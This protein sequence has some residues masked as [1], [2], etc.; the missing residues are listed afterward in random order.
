MLFL[1]S[2]KN[3]RYQLVIKQINVQ[4]NTQLCIKYST[5]VAMFC[6]LYFE[7]YV[8]VSRKGSSFLYLMTYFF[9]SNLNAWPLENEHR[10]HLNLFFFVYM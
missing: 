3:Y 2:Q 6:V 7:I 8:C 10:K 1:T 9:I 4:I 5:F